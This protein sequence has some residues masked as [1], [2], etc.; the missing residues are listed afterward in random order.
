MLQ[1]HCLN[2][3]NLSIERKGSV[4]YLLLLSL[5]DLTG[6]VLPCKTRLSFL[7]V[8]SGLGLPIINLLHAVIEHGHA[9]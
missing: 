6:T 8:C 7:L 1:V 9:R 5:V 4:A 3:I 2:R